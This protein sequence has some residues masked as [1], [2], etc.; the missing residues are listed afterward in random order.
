MFCYGSS[1]LITRVL[2]VPDRASLFSGLLLNFF[3]WGGG[4][5]GGW[6]GGGPA[7]CG[8]YYRSSKH[9]RYVS[10]EVVSGTTDRATD[11]AMDKQHRVMVRRLVGR[12]V[13]LIETI[14]GSFLECA[15]YVCL[16]LYRLTSR[17]STTNFC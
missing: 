15:P 6:G 12:S 5:G 8:V 17:F 2:M 7:P 4:G 1:F 10:Q 9:L 3:S 16:S 14:P 11:H 13:M